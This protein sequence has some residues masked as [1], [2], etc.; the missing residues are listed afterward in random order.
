MRKRRRTRQRLKN[1]RL[2]GGVQGRDGIAKTPTKE[3]QVPE[4]TCAVSEEE[5]S[6]D[7]MEVPS[8]DKPAEGSALLEL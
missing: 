2:H 1:R 3:W 6:L 5:E 4:P 7:P 8:E